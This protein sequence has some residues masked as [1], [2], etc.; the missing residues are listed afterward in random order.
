MVFTLKM[1]VTIFFAELP[2]RKYTRSV[3]HLQREDHDLFRPDI[4]T[5][6]KVTNALHLHSGTASIS[7]A[8]G[9]EGA[10]RR[11]RRFEAERWNMHANDIA[12]P[13]AANRLTLG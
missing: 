12:V 1:V 7:I 10:T 9:R 2:T 3:P 13:T 11:T 4:Q 8:Y 6:Q 5:K